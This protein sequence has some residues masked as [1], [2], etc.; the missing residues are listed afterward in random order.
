MR[1]AAC[2]S[3]EAGD[4]ECG[5]RPRSGWRSRLAE[6]RDSAS[7][8]A[9][10]ILVG[11]MMAFGLARFVAQGWVEKVLI[12]PTY[13]FKYPGFEWTVVGPPWVL[14]THFAVTAG[15]A[16]CVSLGL[17]YRP[18]IVVYFLGFLYLQLLDVTLYL[19]HYHLVILVSGIFCLLPLGER[20]SL[21]VWLGRRPRRATVPAWMIYLL[22]LQVTVVY[23]HAALAKAQ[24]D[25][26][27]HA[28][29]LGI[30]LRARSEVPVLGDLFAQPWAPMLFSWGGFLYDLTIWI[31]LLVPRTRGWAYLAVLGFHGCTWLLF[32]IG[33]FPV[34]MAVLTT[35]FFEPN[36]PTRIRDRLRRRLGES[37]PAPRA[38][39]AR[40][41]S[42]GLAAAL[43][44]Y[45]AF[46]L[47][48][49]LRSH[50]MS[51]SVL[52][53]E[54]GMR[55][56][57]KV[58][59]REKNGDVTYRVRSKVTGREWQVPAEKY[60]TWRQLSDM[61]G[62]PDL[63]MDLGKHVAWDFRR[64]GLGPVE[65][66]VDAWVSL[67]GRPARRLVDPTIDVETIDRAHGMSAWIA[68]PPTEPPLA[69]HPWTP[70]S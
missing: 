39:G 34:I 44:L 23:L 68:P 59:V 35:V 15:A 17:F 2:T 30:W 26:L 5:S 58:M 9:L 18:A 3:S 42:L 62:Q 21:D 57:W 46:Q 13:F 16:V 1:L 31:F 41:V 22:R 55:Y 11:A 24:P 4:G 45:S 12:E 25:W 64:R 7:L 29:P 63:I 67:N 49:P 66:R 47:L 14:Y 70:S 65:V 32:D 10:R 40:P 51:D 56:S 50:L 60:L 69:A 6:P 52:W 33:M 28:Q 38:S 27:L 37:P 20:A 61:S 48:F 53:T 43:V 19:N 8:A 54:L 36:W